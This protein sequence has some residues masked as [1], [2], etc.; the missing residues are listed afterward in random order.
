MKEI[1]ILFS[2]EMVR[3]ILEGRKTQTR[4]I[5]KPQPETYQGESG[6]QFELPG[7][8]T[9][10]GAKRFTEFSKIQIGYRL[11]ARETTWHIQHGNTCNGTAVIYRADDYCE[12][13]PNR[14]PTGKLCCWRPSIHMP[15]WA[16]RLTLEVTGVRV[17]RL[18]DISETDAIAE[19]MDTIRF[20]PGDYS[21]PTYDLNKSI[22]QNNFS[23]LWDSLYAKRGFGWDANPWVWVI[24]FKKANQNAGG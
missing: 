20:T 9:S 13:F 10:L 12:T 3:A 8:H 16:S 15:R 17:E 23:S 7:W 14:K 6:L 4:R 22:A 5:V 2:G 19:G 1:P 21:H 24:E 18:E 11:W